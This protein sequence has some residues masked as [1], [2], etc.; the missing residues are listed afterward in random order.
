[1]SRTAWI[2]AAKR[3]GSGEW[4]GIRCPENN[5]DDLVVDWLPGPESGAGEYWLHCPTCGAQNFLRVSGM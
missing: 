5:D 3:V 2:E 1:M 4:T